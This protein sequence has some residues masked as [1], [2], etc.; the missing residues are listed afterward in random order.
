MVTRLHVTY[1]NMDIDNEL[2][3]KIFK[4]LNSLDF[5]CI[6]REHSEITWRRVLTFE[7]HTKQR[8]TR[9]YEKEALEGATKIY[10]KHSDMPSDEEVKEVNESSRNQEVKLTA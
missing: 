9:L 8:N 2:E 7:K 3:K 1:R 6:N 5:V 10:G 4:F